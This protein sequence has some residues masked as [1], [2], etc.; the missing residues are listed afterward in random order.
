MKLD[1]TPI[2]ELLDP[3]N[4]KATTNFTP[5][6]IVPFNTQEAINRIIE[7]IGGTRPDGKPAVSMGFCDDWMDGILDCLP[8]IKM[9]RS[10]Q[11]VQIGVTNQGT[12]LPA[13][14]AISTRQGRDGTMI[15]IVTGPGQAAAAPVVAAKRG[16]RDKLRGMKLG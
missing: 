3:R 15:Q 8:A 9:R 1:Q 4:R 7:R 16:F 2:A 6:S 10:E 12:K 11:I 14:D 13:G 5:E